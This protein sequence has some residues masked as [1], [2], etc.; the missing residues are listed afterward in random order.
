M[1]VGRQTPNSSEPPLLSL[2]TWKRGVAR[3]LD[4]LCGSC[5]QVMKTHERCLVWKGRKDEVDNTGRE[6][7]EGARE[8]SKQSW[9]GEAKQY[10]VFIFTSR[11]F[12]VFCAVLSLAGGRYYCEIHWRVCTCSH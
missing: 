3:L 9:S 8:R 1:V 6:E 2:V 5:V 10:L 12:F 11:D 4:A 7:D